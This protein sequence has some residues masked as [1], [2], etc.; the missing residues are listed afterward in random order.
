MSTA[1]TQKKSRGRPPKQI[2]G[3]HQTRT[4]LLRAGVEVLTEKGFTAT[5]IDEI[6]RRVGVPKGSFYHYFGSK[7]SLI[8][9]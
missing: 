8:H 3:Q 7:L 2:G 9:I 4:A 1:N 5:G 6:L